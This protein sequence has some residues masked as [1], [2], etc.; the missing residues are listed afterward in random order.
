MVRRLQGAR[1][2]KSCRKLNNRRLIKGVTKLGRA[3]AAA[4][5]RTGQ[6]AARPCYTRAGQGRSAMNMLPRLAGIAAALAV[7]A[8]P[9][10]GQS[11]PPPAQ[12]LAELRADVQGRADHQT[13]P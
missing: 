9:A 8:G 7:F 2:G 11:S 6:T 4:P 12:A 10:L 3:R 13:Y 5:P 1:E